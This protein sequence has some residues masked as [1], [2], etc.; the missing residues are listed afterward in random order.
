MRR[1]WRRF[2]CI[3]VLTIHVAGCS[4]WRPIPQGPDQAASIAEYDR[5]RVTLISDTVL[6]VYEPEFAETALRGFGARCLTERT[7]LSQESELCEPLEI[8][9]AEVG[10]IAARR[11]SAFHTLALVGGLIGVGA[12][13]DAAV[14]PGLNGL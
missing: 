10:E 7:G 13:L 1:A 4:A 3:V 2:A 11:F 12:V 9:R 14:N 8:P 6:E 5:V